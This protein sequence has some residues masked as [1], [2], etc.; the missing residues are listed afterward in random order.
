MTDAASVDAAAP[1]DASDNTG[2]AD[3]GDT[4]DGAT[5]P[6]PYGTVACPI[7]P[8]GHPKLA[9]GGVSPVG[10]GG[11]GGL[12]G[13]RAGVGSGGCPACGMGGPRYGDV[14]DGAVGPESFSAPVPTESVSS[15]R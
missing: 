13:I 10:L 9:D 15:R 1:L 14:G 6:A 4:G 2:V 3:A 12:S 11:L 8:G 5:N 7:H